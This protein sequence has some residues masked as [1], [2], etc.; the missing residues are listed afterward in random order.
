MN[1]PRMCFRPEACDPADFA[2]DWPTT[3]PTKSGSTCLFGA[4]EFGYK[5]GTCCLAS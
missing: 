2:C 4:E 3:A 5:L 1:E